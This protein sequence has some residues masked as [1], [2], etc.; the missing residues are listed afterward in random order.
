MSDAASHPAAAH[1]A[2]PPAPPV[3]RTRWVLMTLLG[4]LA[5]TFIAASQTRDV[6]VTNQQ[7]GLL[8]FAFQAAPN[9]EAPEG[10]DQ[11]PIVE[12]SP[13]TKGRPRPSAVV[14]DDDTEAAAPVETPRLKPPKVAR[15]PKPAPTL[16]AVAEAPPAFPVTLSAKHGHLYVVREPNSTREPLIVKV[17]SFSLASTV[18]PPTGADP[19]QGP[20]G[21]LQGL[22][23]NFPPHIRHVV[24]DV[25]TNAE[26]DSKTDFWNNQSIGFLWF[27]P[28][29]TIATHTPH[30][31]DVVRVTGLTQQRAFMFAMAVAPQNMWMKMHS[32]QVSGC[33]SLLPMNSKARADPKVMEGSFVGSDAAFPD[34]RTAK[35]GFLPCIETARPA[36]T[37]PVVRGEDVLK[38]IPP[39]IRVIYMSVDAQGFDLQVLTSVSIERLKTVDILLLECQDLPEGH[40]MFLTHGSFS[41]SEI[42]QCVEEALP[43]RMADPR[44][45]EPTDKCPINNP[46]HERNCVFRLPDRPY[47]HGGVD[48]LPYLLKRPAYQIKHPPRK[49]LKCPAFVGAE[50]GPAE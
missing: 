17:G 47:F 5:L 32:S 28:Q 38:L 22:Y 2:P 10:G 8:A 20:A 18:A 43:H 45:G 36:E 12:S 46:S 13:P 3:E 35:D 25:G 40:G 29:M 26:P 37:I 30:L 34:W 39:W 9:T 7:G 16:D 49:V 23:L 50:G 31:D 21:G 4:L 24:F 1:L 27:E 42:R 41:C 19:T 44:T 14:Q 15:Q 48:A 33:N 11:Q 6:V